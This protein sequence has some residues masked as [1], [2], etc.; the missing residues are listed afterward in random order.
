MNGPSQLCTFL[1]EDLSFGVDVQH[2]QEVIRFQRVTPVPLA[3]SALGG[4]IN[5]RGHVVPVIDLRRRLHLA[6]RERGRVPMNIVI[7]TDDGLVGLLVDE[8][9]DVVEVNPD[10]YEPRPDTVCGRLWELI[11]SIYKLPE[12]LLLV[13]ETERTVSVD[14]AERESA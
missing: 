10:M 4:L 1:V 6:D 12:R 7:R 5:L 14:W 13:L 2:V 8:I 11:D 3:D 9:V